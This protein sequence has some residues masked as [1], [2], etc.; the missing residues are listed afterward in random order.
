MTGDGGYRWGQENETAG[1]VQE[2]L[3]RGASRGF[4]PVYHDFYSVLT[5][6]ETK[7]PST[8]TQHI[9]TKCKMYC[10]SVDANSFRKRLYK[11]KLANFG[12]FIF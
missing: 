12:Y 6:S 7:F 10:V 4:P 1:R 11:I 2:R 9:C 8:G 5:L 3:A